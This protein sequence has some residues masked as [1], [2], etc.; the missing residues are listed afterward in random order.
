MLI[1]DFAQG[2]HE[3]LLLHSNPAGMMRRKLRSLARLFYLS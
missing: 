3:Y 2:G 1:D